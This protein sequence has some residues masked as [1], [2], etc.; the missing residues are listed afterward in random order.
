[1]DRKW[2]IKTSAI[3]TLISGCTLVAGISIFMIG[4][5]IYAIDEELPEITIWLMVVVTGI[6]YVASLIEII[7]GICAI[8][9]RSW[10]W[11]LAGSIV[12]A[13][14]N[15]PLGLAALILLLASEAQ[16]TVPD[17]GAT[18]FYSA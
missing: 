4:L 15:W 10:G 5:F 3:L 9:R 1:M 2:M 7:G 13:M 12:A 6:C 8:F 16:F 11:A 18:R 14:F 17:S